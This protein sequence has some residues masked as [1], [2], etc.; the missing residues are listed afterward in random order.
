MSFTTSSRAA[1]SLGVYRFL[2]RIPWLRRSFKAKVLSIAFL[3]THVPLLAILA[4]FILGSAVTQSYALQILAIALVAT[5]LG[6]LATLLALRV[7]LRPIDL[8][9]EMLGQF[10]QGSHVVRPRVALHDEMGTLIDG[11]ARTLAELGAH[12]QHVATHDNVTG[13]LNTHGLESA[14]NNV[15]G[16]A[17]EPVT[18]VQ[19]RVR[20]FTQMEVSLSRSE[21]EFVMRSITD[22]LRLVFPSPCQIAV[23]GRGQ[24]AVLI[25]SR[26][27]GPALDEWLDQALA[28]LTA[29]MKVGPALLAPVCALGVAEA[30]DSKSLGD[31]FSAAEAGLLAAE[32]RDGSSWVRASEAGDDRRDH[33]Q[34]AFELDKALSE[35]QLFAVYQ[36]RVNI[37]SGRIESVEALVRWRHP[38]RGII[39]PGVFIPMAERTGKI[40]EIGRYILDR[41][42]AQA[43]AWE[44]AGR[45]VTVSVNMAA[46]QI[47]EATLVDDVRAALARHGLSPKYLELEITETSLLQKTTQSVKPLEEIRNLG[48]TVALDDFGTGYSSLS[49]LSNLPIDRVKIDRSFVSRLDVARDRQIV[50]GIVALCRALGLAITA[51][52]VETHDQADALRNMGCDEWQGF[53]FAYPTVSEEIDWHPR[54]TATAASTV[55]VVCAAHG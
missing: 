38:E 52:G 47:A 19:I 18:L 45:P 24:F 29:R 39:S 31:L 49:Y 23:F 12:L 34:L 13:A 6:T 11:T 21:I 10:R 4:Y 1:P 7:L 44:Q 9:L 14:L 54:S 37:R 16:V 53:L 36:P 2:E 26:D 51:E 20:N 50:E 28:E 27:A 8:T 48:V 15:Q 32:E 55:G 43:A 40:L 17:S 35:A 30:S 33:L 3:G 46:A 22:R 25:T 5:L 42:V 41:A